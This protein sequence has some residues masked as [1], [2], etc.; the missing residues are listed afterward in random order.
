MTRD[1]AEAEVPSLNLDAGRVITLFVVASSFLA[2]TSVKGSNQGCCPKN[3]PKHAS[4]TVLLE[5][6]VSR[7]EQPI[8]I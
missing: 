7:K 8:Y 2:T 1:P 6:R 4:S 3:L 5:E